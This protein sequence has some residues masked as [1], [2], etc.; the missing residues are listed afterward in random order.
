MV[1]PAFRNIVQST[2][3]IVRRR[4]GDGVR[5]VRQ[6]NNRIL[7]HR[8]R[9]RREPQRW[10][11]QWLVLVG[12]GV[13][14]LALLA[15]DLTPTNAFVPKSGIIVMLGFAC[16]MVLVVRA[17]TAPVPLWIKASGVLAAL[18]YPMAN[19]IYG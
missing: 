12:P 16:A 14:L 11:N 3:S 7:L 4:G 2:R 10:W 9:R 6:I 19:A 15:V 5:R 1:K 8:R 17:A 13:L 18:L